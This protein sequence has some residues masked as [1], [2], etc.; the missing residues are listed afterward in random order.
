[1]NFGDMTAAEV[2][3]MH[4]KRQAREKA[5]RDSYDS[6]YIHGRVY[7]TTYNTPLMDNKPKTIPNV[8]IS[9]VKHLIQGFN[10]ILTLNNFTYGFKEIS[11]FRIEN[12]TDY[13]QEGG[14][15]D[16][17]IIVGMPSEESPTLECKRGLMIRSAPIFSNASRAAAAMI[18]NDLAR[19]AALMAVNTQDPQATLEQGPA[20]GTID[21]YDINK[22][23]CAAYTF[24]SLGMRTWEC[25]GLSA[26]SSGILIESITIAHTGLTRIPLGA[27]NTFF[28]YIP[29]ET[30]EQEYKS[31]NYGGY[32]LSF[33]IDR[34]K[35]LKKQAKYLKNQE[36]TFKKQK[37]ELEKA[38][39]DRQ[40][41][42]E[43]LKKAYADLA[44]DLKNADEKAKAAEE[45]SKKDYEEEAEKAEKEKESTA[46]A[47]AEKE[48]E[49]KQAAKEENEK[50]EENRKNQVE[51]RQKELDEQAEA[52]EKADEARAEADKAAEE[53]AKAKQEEAKAKAE[54]AEA[55][56]Q[57]N[58]VDDDAAKE[59]AQKAQEEAKAKAEEAE[60][61]KQESA[62]DDDTAK[63]Q[64]EKARSEAKDKAEQAEAKKQGGSE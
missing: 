21:V 25:D 26:D 62:V 32:W 63:E 49:A 53:E 14:V 16:H 50:A 7:E 23:L 36:K 2:A 9:P 64:A 20:L 44:E 48:A 56:K 33:D 60:A 42:L 58:A 12:P 29:A 59:E 31:G 40:K 55:K 22:R 28:G 51:A 39:E 46:L 34:L 17:K 57:E 3:E 54:E 6:T 27:P 37:E 30:E 8:A 13:I 61:K 43:E 18:Q 19:Q 5:R 15:N 1:M 41:N 35:Q 47:N 24:M 52:V 4:A 38:K 10:F 11:G 45:K